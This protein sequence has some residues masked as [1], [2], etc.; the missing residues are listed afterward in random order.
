MMDPVREL[1]IRANF[2]FAGIG[3]GDEHA[4][5]RLG[6]LRGV[7]ADSVQQKHCLA[8][9][10]REVGFMSW[11]H[12]K[13]VLEG[14][15]GANDEGA[16]FG[17][18]LYTGGMLNEW[19]AS[20]EEARARL[21]GSSERRFLLAYKRHFLVV[22]DDFIEALGMSPDDPDWAAIGWDWARPRDVAARSRLYFQRLDAMRRTAA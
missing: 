22:M 4:L 7:S 21:D 10:A 20:Y 2:L 8:V 15:I 11:E 9:V 13:R 12:A 3:R 18:M 16:D 6:A 1:K 5:A 14:A 19:F 17:T